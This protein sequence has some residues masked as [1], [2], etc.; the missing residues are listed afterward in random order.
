MTQHNK[1]IQSQVESTAFFSE[2]TATGAGV[3]ATGGGMGLARG[4]GA[5]GIGMAPVAA[6]GAVVGRSAYGLK[7]FVDK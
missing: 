7:R 2:D 1:N 4:F 6:T 5:M 3:S